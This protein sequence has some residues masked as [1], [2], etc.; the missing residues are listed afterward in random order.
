MSAS[1]IRTINFQLQC[2][3]CYLNFKDYDKIMIMSDC[4]HYFH[5][6]CVEQWI[7]S[8]NYCPICRCSII[9]ENLVRDMISMCVFSRISSFYTCTE[10]ADNLDIIKQTIREIVIRGMKVHFESHDITTRQ[11][12]IDIVHYYRDKICELLHLNTTTYKILEHPIVKVYNIYTYRNTLL[13][14]ILRKGVR[15]IP[16]DDSEDD[17]EEEEPKRPLRVIRGVISIFSA[18]SK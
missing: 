14:N 12:L 4:D 10:Y 5:D 3:I 1:R 11:K 15:I 9:P 6:C 7:H 17:E 18:L 16:A 13:N 8:N 2:S